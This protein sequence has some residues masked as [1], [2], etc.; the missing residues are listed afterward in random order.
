M[1]TCAEEEGPLEMYKGMVARGMLQHDVR[2][3]S[4]AEALNQLLGKMREHEKSM[5]IYQ[6]SSKQESIALY[7]T[8][9]FNKSVRV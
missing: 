4:V 9:F 8:I 2:Q 6:V 1:L 5:K 3:E 7:S